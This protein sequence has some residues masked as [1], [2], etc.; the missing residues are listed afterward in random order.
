ME[1]ST[2]VLGA[3]AEERATVALEAAGYSIVARNWTCAVGELDVV[4][5]DGDILV[6]VEV[7]SR[8]SASHGHAAEMVTASKRAKVTRV[9]QMYLGLERP[10]FAECRFDV[11]AITAGE[12]AIVKDAWRLG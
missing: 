9:A 5:R 7:R 10:A 4:A 12:L 2:K 3:S 8:A 11:V 1:T 6:F